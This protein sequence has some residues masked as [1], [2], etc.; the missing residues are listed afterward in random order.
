MTI[1]IRRAA[2]ADAPALALVGAATFLESYSGVIDGGALMR[3]C[4]EKQTETVYAAALADRDQAL[5]L[6]E[7]AP[8]AAPVGYL[9]LAPPDLPVETGPDDLE[10]KRIYVLDKLQRSGLGAQLLAACE[11][12]ARARGAARLLLGVYKGNARALSFYDRVGFARCGERAFDV[13]GTVYQDWVLA[14]PI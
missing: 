8:G 12:E 10:I 2:S 3:H 5:W 7:A 14:K 6:A 11:G 4:A 13:G 1:S 9:H